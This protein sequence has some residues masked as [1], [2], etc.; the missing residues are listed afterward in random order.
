MSRLP[1]FHRVHL[2]RCAGSF[3]AILLTLA[4]MNKIPCLLS[5][6]SLCLW[7]AMPEYGSISR[8]KGVF[9]AVWGFRVGLCC[10][11]GL[12]GLC[13]FCTRVELGG[14]KA[15]GVFASIYSFICLYLP[16]FLSLY[17]HL[18]LLSFVGL[19][20]FRFSLFVLWFS[21]WVFVFSFSLTDYTQKE[22]ALRFCSLRPLFACCVCSDSRT[23][24]EKLLRCVFGFF[25]F[26]RLILPTN[27]CRV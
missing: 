23:I 16:F 17:L 7:R 27:T 6:L 25:Q 14:L 20:A 11:G 22:R 18:V 10:L 13:G 19:V 4:K 9:S 8:F 2:C 15:C 21:L 1:A 5:A 26:V 24:I 12:R 3:G